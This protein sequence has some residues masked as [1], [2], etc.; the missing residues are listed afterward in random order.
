[1]TQSASSLFRSHLL[2]GIGVAS[3]AANCV[4]DKGAPLAVFSAYLESLSSHI[5]LVKLGWTSSLLF[6]DDETRQKIKL[7]QRKGVDVCLG[8][9][10]S[11][12]ACDSGLF[13]GLLEYVKELGMS[14]LEIGS[15][16]A[17]DPAEVPRLTRE[18]KMAGLTVMVEI[19]YKDPERDEQMSIEDRLGYIDAALLAG[20]DYIVLEAREVGAGYSVF[21]E[22]GA[23]NAQLLTAVLARVP[24]DNL[25]FEAPT[26]ST[27]LEILR[28]VGFDALLGNIPFDEIPRVE[29]FRRRLHADTYI[30]KNSLSILRS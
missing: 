8:G 25:I 27:Q 9:T 18:A 10:L 30:V 4:L 7:A 26:R 22:N 29:T 3:N 23:Q 11:E 19:G 5:R 15:G 1:V 28:R 21:R 14:L 2:N 6:S 12:I 24:R 17:V 16:F 20:A 13:A